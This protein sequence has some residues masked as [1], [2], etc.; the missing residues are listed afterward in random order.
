MIGRRMKP[1]D[2]RDLANGMALLLA[3]EDSDA[4]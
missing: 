3:V 4:R 1:T 2:R